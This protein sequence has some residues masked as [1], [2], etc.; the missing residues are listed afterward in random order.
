MREMSHYTTILYLKTVNLMEEKEP[1]DTIDSV[2]VTFFFRY[3]R[4]ISVLLPF[5]N[6]LRQRRACSSHCLVLLALPSFTI[7][8]YQYCAF[9]SPVAPDRVGAALFG[10]LRG[11]E[12][13]ALGQV[14]LV[15]LLLVVFCPPAGG[16]S[17]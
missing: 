4:Q 13:A 7:N 10:G 5:N 9:P 14:F 11:V 3:R 15:V 1:V 2:T 17:L 12:A 16:C 6:E 8:P